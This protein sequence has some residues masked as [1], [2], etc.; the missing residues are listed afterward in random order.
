LINYD[1]KK[2]KFFENSIRQFIANN[3]I[4][5]QAFLN[6][7]FNKDSNFNLFTEEES[8]IKF[9]DEYSKNDE[10]NLFITSYKFSNDKVLLKDQKGNLFNTDIENFIRVLGRKKIYNK[11]F[12][13]LSKEKEFNHNQKLSK[14]FIPELKTNIYFDKNY[15]IKVSKNKRKILINTPYSDSSLII[16][17][18]N[19]DNWTI[20]YK[21][22]NK[23]IRTS[24]NN[25]SERMDKYGFTGCLN[26]LNIKFNMTNLKID[27]AHC[28]DSLNII[29]SKGI[30]NDL[31][32]E[33]AKNDA[34]DMDFSNIKTINT[35]INNA[36]NDCI[37]VS[38]GNYFFK[39]AYVSNCQDKGVSIG[40][41]SS[42][43]V[44]LLKSNKTGTSMAVKDYSKLHLK[45]G[46]L[47]NTKT[48]A[49]VFQ[50]KEEFGGAII[51]IQDI[52]C[53]GEYLIDEHSIFNYVNK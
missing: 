39:N 36:G 26:L 9:I 51:N 24:E 41:K 14:F 43:I 31:T 19:F 11:S 20:E 35:T 40:E 13:L 52:D 34:L 2:K 1:S 23:K 10:N 3:Q 25:N 6:K 22:G 49:S 12:V 47:I 5:L 33:N 37:D 50:K 32:I 4:L 28:E 44:D 45:K 7:K 16:S 15:E 48:C 8:R 46:S 53:D 42:V 30:I 21:G 27:N 18:G 38:G 17:G 29:S